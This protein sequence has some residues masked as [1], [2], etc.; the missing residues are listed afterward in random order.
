MNKIINFRRIQKRWILFSWICK[1]SLFQVLQ[2]HE[3]LLLFC[4]LKKKKERERRIKRI[5][6]VR[7]KNKQ[8]LKSK[9]A[10]LV[11]LKTSSHQTEGA[12]VVV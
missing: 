6:S 7:R 2:I 3:N 4:G 8:C 11:I 9:K 5:L 1:T 10:K 12:Q